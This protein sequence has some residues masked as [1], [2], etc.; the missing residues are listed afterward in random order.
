MFVALVQ[1]NVCDFAACALRE[2][3]ERG[4]S[5]RGLHEFF[6]CPQK[7]GRSHAQDFAG[8]AAKH[9]LFALHLVQRG[10]LVRERLVLGAWVAKIGR[11]SCR[12]RVSVG[13]G[14]GTLEKRGVAW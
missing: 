1:R 9:D 13:G 7:S 10:E 4:K 6:A 3:A 5:R 14:G 12:D 8:A 2:F 11:A